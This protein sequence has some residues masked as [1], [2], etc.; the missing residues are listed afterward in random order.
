MRVLLLH[1]RYRQPGGEDAVFQAEAAMLRAQGLDVLA[2][3]FDNEPAD[4]VLGEVALLAQSSWSLSSY[5]TLSRVCREF[6]PPRLSRAPHSCYDDE[7]GKGG[8]M[9]QFRVFL[10]VGLAALLRVGLSRINP[11]GYGRQLHQRGDIPP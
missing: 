11:D 8:I 3:E 7:Q 5:R 6:R 2:Q 9:R 1:N 10:A 4:G